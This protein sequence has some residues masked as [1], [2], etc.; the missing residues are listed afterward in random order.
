MW[1]SIKRKRCRIK[2]EIAPVLR[3]ELVARKSRKRD[4][5]ELYLKEVLRLYE[6]W[7]DVGLA[8]RY[9]RR[10]LDL[11][12][13]PVRDVHPIRRIIDSTS[14]EPD[15]KKRSRWGRALQYALMEKAQGDKLGE[16]FR[17]NGGIAGCARK[18]ARVQPRRQRRDDWA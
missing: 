1:G 13:L 4:A 9:S 12:D 6:N 3:A 8:K 18:V 7:K 10:A 5:A 17:E 16:F 14:T 11:V 15:R 2:A